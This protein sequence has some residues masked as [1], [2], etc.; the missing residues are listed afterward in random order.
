MPAR[1]ELGDG[2][3]FVVALVPV[4]VGVVGVEE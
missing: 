3:V 4:R 2:V 1:S